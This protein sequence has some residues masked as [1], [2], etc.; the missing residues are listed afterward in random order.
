MVLAGINAINQVVAQRYAN[1]RD[2]VVAPAGEYVLNM[3]KQLNI[4]YD[5]NGRKLIN[6]DFD[7]E[8]EAYREDQRIVTATN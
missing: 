2:I 4:D 3:T 5:P 6:D 1:V 8:L 7:S